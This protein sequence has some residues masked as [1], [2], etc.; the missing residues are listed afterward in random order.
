MIKEGVDSGSRGDLTQGA[1]A[2]HPVISFVPLH[3]SA[4]DRSENLE[5][6]I[7]SLWDDGWGELE[8][9][10][11]EDWFEEGQLFLVVPASRSRRCCC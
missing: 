9:L 6:W 10:S 11:P 8:K 4:L 1:M 7:W 2:E 3:L 5:P